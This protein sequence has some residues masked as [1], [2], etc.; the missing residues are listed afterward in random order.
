[1]VVIT[2]GMK[3]IYF[4]LILPFTAVAQG[5][6]GAGP[7]IVNKYTVQD[8]QSA[9]TIEIID[10]Q[11]YRQ[12]NDRYRFAAPN[13]SDYLCCEVVKDGEEP[14]LKV[15][16]VRK[17]YEYIAGM[18][19]FYLNQFMIG[20]MKVKS[21]ELTFHNDTLI[22]FKSDWS[23]DIA[24]AMKHKYGEPE[25]YRKVDTV[26]CTYKLTGANTYNEKY[27]Y[28]STWENA[29][30]VAKTILYKDYNSKCEPTVSSSY[31]YYDFY[32]K[33]ALKE[34]LIISEGEHKKVQ[35]DRDAAKYDKF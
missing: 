30:V 15:L 5:F 18:R 8:L 33:E 19:Y 14:R 32:K 1:M 12:Y 11:D 9:C 17:D 2:D 27:I 25:L 28:I 35:S 29:N 16:Y 22:A 10:N 31:E 23:L 6:Q 4:I 20:D 21:I 13:S 7:F 3:Y 24:N 26:V 34:A